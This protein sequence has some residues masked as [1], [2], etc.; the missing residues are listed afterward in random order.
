MNVKFGV[1]L[2]NVKLF[3][4]APTFSELKISASICISDIKILC[5]TLDNGT[6]S[7]SIWPWRYSSQLMK[8]N[9]ATFTLRF[10]WNNKVSYTIVFDEESPNLIL[11]TV[12]LSRNFLW[13]LLFLI[14]CH[15]I[16]LSKGSVASL[17]MYDVTVS[18]A[19]GEISQMIFKL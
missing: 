9:L 10:Y 11:G 2:A 19:K 5:Y 8:V 14:H 15:T 6:L 7:S 16:Q 13:H 12:F 18:K 3:W 1:G 17:L 4:K